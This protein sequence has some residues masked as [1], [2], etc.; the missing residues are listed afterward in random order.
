MQEEEKG[1]SE[2]RGEE[3][4][5]QFNIYQAAVLNKLLAHTGF[6]V[7]PHEIVQKRQNA[8]E[9]KPTLNKKKKPVYDFLPVE[10]DEDSDKDPSLN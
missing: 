5:L 4:G 1:T 10:F 6:R 7:E 8:P 3:G 2:V 9:R